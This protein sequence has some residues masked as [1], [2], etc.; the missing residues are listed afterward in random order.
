[1]LHR[2]ALCIGI[3][4][5]QHFPSATLSGCVNDAQDMASLLKDLLGFEDSDITRLSDQAATKANIMR[6]LKRMVEG[7]LAGRYDHLVFTFS[8][9]GT[10][11]PDL[12]LDEF[13]RADEAFCPH[14]L[15]P[16]GP[17]WD[18]DHLIVDDELHDLFVQL[19]STV[20]LEVLLD[21]CHSGAG[22]RAADL[23]MDRRPRYLPP[24]SV[25]AFRDI[26]YRHARPAH[27]KLL[28]KGL[29]HHI[30]WTAC[31]QNQTAA[32]AFLDGAWHGAFTY[33]F[34]RE[35]RASGNHLSRAKVLAKIRSD[36]GVA[37]FTQTPQLDCEA[38]TRHAVMRAEAVPANVT[39]LPT[40]MPT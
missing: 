3:N 39:P 29:S 16:S 36:L 21:T 23:L 5:Y 20:I 34:C 22:L 6:E 18:R 25:E 24:P 38:V 30:L 14:D 28:E 11:V 15:A 1:M 2:T 19:P 7:A 12:N 8:G 27:Q 32:D 17:Q 10:Q 37:H 26:E 31:K 40:D 4:Q 33:H 9:H 13:D 35:A